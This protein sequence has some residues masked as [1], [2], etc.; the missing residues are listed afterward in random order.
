VSSSPAI[1]KGDANFGSG[2]GTV[3]KVSPA[4][5]V[6]ENYSS[7]LSRNTGDQSVNFDLTRTE[8]SVQ[9]QSVTKSAKLNKLIN[10]QQKP[11]SD[12]LSQD[13]EFHETSRFK[14]FRGPEFV[15]H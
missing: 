4:I 13:G 9:D 1:F 8:T 14:A 12:M 11:Q 7:R 6:D 2:Y 3:S 5:V 10:S 15:R